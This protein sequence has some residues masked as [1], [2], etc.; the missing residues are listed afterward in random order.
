VADIGTGSG[1]IAIS[2]ARLLPD[3]QVWAVDASPAALEVARGNARRHGVG[4]RIVFLVGNLVVPLPGPVDVLVAN[5][6][7]VSESEYAS[8]PAGIRCYEPCGALLA[9]PDGLSA[10]RALLRTAGPALAE[11]GVILLEIGAT[12]GTAALELACA[13]FPGAV[14]SLIPDRSSHDRVLR[15]ERA[16]PEGPLSRQRGTHLAG[17]P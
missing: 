10:I 16:H 17:R 5:L 8:L 15:V 11:D 7:Y 2:L 12:Q 9:G 14:I 3:A 1:A 4:D 6:P 13:A